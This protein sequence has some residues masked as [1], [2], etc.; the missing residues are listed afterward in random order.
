MMVPSELDVMIKLL[1]PE[2]ACIGLARDG[3]S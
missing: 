2:Q 1:G 3:L